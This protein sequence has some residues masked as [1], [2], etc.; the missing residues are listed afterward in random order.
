MN[1]TFRSHYWD[2][3]AARLALIRFTRELHGL[4]LSAWY[5][6]GF[7]DRDYVPFSFFD[8]ERIVANVCVYLLPMVI[9]GRQYVTPQVSAVGTDPVHRRRGLNRELTT[10][11]LEWCGGRASQFSFLFADEDAF[12]FYE[13]CGFRRVSQHRFVTDAPGEP[14]GGSA[15]RLNVENADDLALLVSLAENR[16]AVSDEI[17]CLS[18]NLLMFHAL[19]TLRDCAYWL[20]EPGVVVFARKNGDIFQVFD[21]V[22]PKIPPLPELLRHMPPV[23][24]HSIEFMFMPDKLDQASVRP[25]ADDDPDG[26]HVGGQG[27]PYETRSFRFPFTAHA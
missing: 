11:A 12:P 20:E 6:H 23:E 15:R 2:D 9:A 18:V 26:T 7:W 17:G 4:D 1:L 27:F 5:D 21:I 10:R 25:V 24:A 22:G 8:G 3:P 14:T 16:T 13:K 19:Y